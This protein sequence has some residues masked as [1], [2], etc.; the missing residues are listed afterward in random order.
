MNDIRLHIIAE[1]QTEQRFVKSILE[2]HLAQFRVYADCRCVLTSK[3][4]RNSKEY[5]GGLST[6]LKAKK[7]IQTWI[8]GDNNQD[9]RFTT[10]FDFY[11]LPE[12]FPG[13]EQIRGISDSYEKVQIL[14][15]ALKADINDYRF[16]PYIQLHEFETLIFVDPEML[17][18]E[19]FD[20]SAAI[21][22]LKQDLSSVKD[23]NPEMINDNPST[24][25]SKRILSVIPDYDKANIGP[26]I[27]ASIGIE[28]LRESCQHFSSWLE[29]L[30]NLA[31]E[32]R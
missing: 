22:R 29:R 32:N 25:P 28:K 14:E 18:A 20:S 4:K 15:N 9:C 12:D 8:K 27:A 19:Y 30:E 16:I 10:M 2:E 7:D 21:E 31:N 24:A 26:E 17:E 1:G 6:Y 3:D 5:R 11:A 23:Q 13:M